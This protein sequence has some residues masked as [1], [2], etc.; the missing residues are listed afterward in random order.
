MKEKMS[1]QNSIGQTNNEQ[2]DLLT[3]NRA[4]ET[5]LNLRIACNKTPYLDG[6]FFDV[7]FGKSS[8]DG[9][10]VYAAC[11]NC[12]PKQ[13]IKGSLKVSS[14]YITHL[15]RKHPDLCSEYLTYKNDKRQLAERSNVNRRTTCAFSLKNCLKKMSLLI[16]CYITEHVTIQHC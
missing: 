16:T 13:L 12:M 3:D 10:I 4:E 6:T 7:D 1:T 14:N 11:T 2:I 9:S 8:Q 5:P 15:K